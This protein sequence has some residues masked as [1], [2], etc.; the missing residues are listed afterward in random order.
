VGYKYDTSD[1]LGEGLIV[2]NDY[3]TNVPEPN[4]LGL[5][6]I[7]ILGLVVVRKCV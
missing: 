5:L 1:T 3:P 6:T 4:T 7:G 2:S